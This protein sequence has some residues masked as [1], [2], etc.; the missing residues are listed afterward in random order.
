ME[1]PQIRKICT[2]NLD[3]ANEE[4]KQSYLPFVDEIKALETANWI[5]SLAAAVVQQCEYNG[6]E[7]YLFVAVSDLDYLTEVLI[8]FGNVLM[9]FMRGSFAE[10]FQTNKSKELRAIVRKK[11]V[12]YANNKGHLLTGRAMFC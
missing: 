10:L 8:A 9:D 4:K 5:S 12:K 6:S 2:S 3:F 1:M 11:C 7:A